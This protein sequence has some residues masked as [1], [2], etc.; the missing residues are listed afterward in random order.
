[1]NLLKTL[2]S[3]TIL[4][5]TTV[6]VF[7]D[8]QPDKP[9]WNLMGM[10]NNPWFR[11]KIH[12]QV[13]AV[14]GDVSLTFE[15][16]T[17][18]GNQNGGWMPKLREHPALTT[19]GIYVDPATMEGTLV[20][21]LVPT[22]VEEVHVKADFDPS[23]PHYSM[24]EVAKHSDHDSAWF[25]VNDKV[26]D[27]TP[28]L[29]AHP[30][31][32]ESILISAG[33]DST[34]EFDAIHSKKA[35]KMLDEYFIGQLTPADVK[36]VE[37]V[38]PTSVTEVFE[39]NAN[40]D[41]IALDPKKRIAFTLSER[42]VLSPDSLLLRFALQSPKHI[43]GLPVGQHMLFS[44]KIN[45]KLVMRAYTPTSSDHDIGHFDLVIKI[46]YA[47]VSA[48]FPEGGKMSQHL[49]KMVVGDS[50]D[51]KG[52]LGHVTYVSRGLLKL[53]EVAHKVKKFTMLCG[54]TGITPIYQVLCAVLRDPKDTT[55]MSLIFANRTEADILLKDEL[56]MLARGH[57]NRLSVHYILSK[58]ADSEKW[59][60][61]GSGSCP[62]TRSIGHLKNELVA[63]KCG[64]GGADSG[65][66]ALLCGPDG[67]L[68]QACDPA[69]EAHGYT[70]EMC[71]Y[72]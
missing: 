18:A 64:R 60:T 4:S 54:G 3:H 67:F 10:L 50:I 59:L 36:G 20:P 23:K 33:M 27:A 37:A 13:D 58:P 40:G 45:G 68:S 28:F 6:G 5:S 30:G 21:A 62:A 32:A 7:F 42:I 19:P 44:A 72:F 66:F 49:G 52:P 47:G 16:P 55:E 31:G 38:T 70:K 17:L 53:G 63:Q 1:M 39:V 11:V 65:A 35:W 51:V 56:D 9:T 26:Y 69:L 43:L 22:I 15:H 25:V 8:T 57:P 48:Q 41:M 46:Y 71:V 2:S 14:S 24:E 34:E 12:K 29:K 61:G